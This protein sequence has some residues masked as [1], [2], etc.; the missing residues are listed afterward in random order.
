MRC[1]RRV[2]RLQQGTRSVTSLQVRGT[3]LMSQRLHRDGSM[4]VKDGRR[5]NT[6]TGSVVILDNISEQKHLSAN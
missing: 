1:I 3:N 5:A 4:S 6:S 2:H